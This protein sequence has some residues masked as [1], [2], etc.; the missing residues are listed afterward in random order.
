MPVRASH[1]NAASGRSAGPTTTYVWARTGV[2]RSL[3]RAARR[4][5]RNHRRAANE[6]R[7]AVDSRQHR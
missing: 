3:P 1:D 7:P 2:V 4:K 5:R 6:R